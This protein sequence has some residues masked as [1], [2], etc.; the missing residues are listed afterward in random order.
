MEGT[1]SFGLGFALAIGTI[2]M[3]CFALG[4]MLGL[5][6]QTPSERD[7]VAKMKEAQKIMETHRNSGW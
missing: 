2:P 6:R 5:P 3:L 4:Y 1:M 7:R